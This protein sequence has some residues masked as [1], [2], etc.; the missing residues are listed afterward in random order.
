LAFFLLHVNVKIVLRNTLL[1]N[2]SKRKNVLLL[3]PK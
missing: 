2:I 1:A 3:V